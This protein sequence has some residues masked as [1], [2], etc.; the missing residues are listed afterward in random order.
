MKI[1]KAKK[2]PSGSWFCR[3]RVNGQDTGI[4][5]P[6]EKEAVAEAMAVKAGTIEAKRSPKS[7]T[8]SAAI[9][10]YISAREN[11]LSPA[12]I[13]G[14]RKIQRNRFGDMMDLDINKITQEKWQRAVNLE[15]RQCGAKTLKNAWMFIS[16]VIFEGTGN[17]VSVRL[18]QVIPNERDFLPAEDI[19]LLLAAL[20]GTDVEI[21]ALLALSSLR[22]SE[23]LGLQ[24]ANIDLGNH[25]LRI[26]ETAVKGEEGLA[27]KV[28]AKNTPSRRTIPII[29]PLQEALEAIAPGDGYV[30]TMAENTIRRKL[31]AVSKKAG[32][33]YVALHGLRH[34][35]ASLAY[36]LGL[37]EEVTMRIGG[38][39][40][41]STMRRIYT[42]V[43]N[44]DISRQSEIFTKF[45]ESSDTS[46][47]GN[48][49][50]N[51]NPQSPV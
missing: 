18:P 40:D 42:H 41:I 11:V 51:E 38:W 24:W 50:G 32:V 9:D 30:V 2:L 20:K 15:A 47:N 17:R 14:Y 43:S 39:S 21:A 25:V 7:K 4:T 37:S 48:E 8:V 49:N 5:R 19:P 12:T 13:H 34:S 26:V 33:Q 22:L 46:Q 45:F 27:R 35:F 16:S 6:T 28:E 31:Q 10:S 29:A 36:H 44:A 23:I 1:P 3:V